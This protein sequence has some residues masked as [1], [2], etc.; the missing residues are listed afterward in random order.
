MDGSQ[1]Q[2]VEN[3]PRCRTRIARGGEA[4]RIRSAGAPLR[5][6]A[7][8]GRRGRDPRLRGGPA[9]PRPRSAGRA[10]GRAGAAGRGRGDGDPR[11]ARRGP[12]PRRLRR[13]PRAA[14]LSTDHPRYL[15]FIPCAPTQEAAAFDVVVGASSIYG[16]SWLEGSGAVY[17]ENQTLRWIAD[18]A[19]LP[20]GGRRRVRARR[21]HRQPVR[22][23]RR[24]AYRPA[25]RAGG[26]F[27]R[28]ALAGR[29]DLRRALVDPVRLRRHGR[30]A[31]RPST[32]TTTG[33]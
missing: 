3:R 10:A 30:R 6:A 2:A 14:C 1:P 33:G 9:Q 31:D 26:R 7:R 15:S 32:P 11:R 22:A 16:G 23:R 21:H 8:A 25:R 19:G 29:H 18:L 13:R 5:P 28:P 17:A 4:T 24:P 12:R 27:G 20:T